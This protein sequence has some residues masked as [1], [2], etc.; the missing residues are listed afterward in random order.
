MSMV[1]LLNKMNLSKI[2]YKETGNQQAMIY[3]CNMSS[4]AINKK[5]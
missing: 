4:N 3:S 5:K 2:I 1:S